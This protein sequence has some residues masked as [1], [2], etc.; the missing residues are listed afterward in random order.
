MVE[1]D[2]DK[3]IKEIAE[4]AKRAKRQELADKRAREKE[5]RAQ[6]I[7][8]TEHQETSE[9]VESTLFTAVIITRLEYEGFNPPSKE[10][11]A[12]ELGTTIMRWANQKSFYAI[13]SK[14]AAPKLVSIDVDIK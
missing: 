7:A 11:L 3:R 8:S 1:N 5:E 10:Q 14:E 2:F 4:K 12:E 13:E 6:K 9:Q